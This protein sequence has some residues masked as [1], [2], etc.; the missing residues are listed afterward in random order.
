[1]L[2]QHEPSLKKWIEVTAKKKGISKFLYLELWVSENF[3]VISNLQ[4]LCPKSYQPRFK[5]NLT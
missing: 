1:M 2:Q 4:S 5:K 3:L